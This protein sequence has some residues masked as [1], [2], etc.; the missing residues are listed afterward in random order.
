MKIEQ[1]LYGCG[2]KGGTKSVATTTTTTT[3][4]STSQPATTATAPTVQPTRG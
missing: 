3:T 2:C 1:R 4:T